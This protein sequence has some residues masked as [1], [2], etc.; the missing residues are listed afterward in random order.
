[1][2]PVDAAKL[3]RL[4]DDANFFALLVKAGTFPPDAADFKHYTVTIEDG[5]RRHSVS[6]VDPVTD[7]HLAAL[8]DFVRETGG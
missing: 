3:A 1:M 7:V 5:T 2:G 8:R 6:F 4:I